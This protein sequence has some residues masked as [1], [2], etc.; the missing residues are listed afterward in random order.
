MRVKDLFATSPA[1]PT[2][3]VILAWIAILLLLLAVAALMSPP[4]GWLIAGAIS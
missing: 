1:V 4:A 3:V 2:V